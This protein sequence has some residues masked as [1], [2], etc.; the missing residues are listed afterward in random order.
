M[1]STG[2]NLIAGDITAFKKITSGYFLVKYGQN[3][4]WSNYVTALN[5]DGEAGARKI[6]YS[7]NQKPVEDIDTVMLA[8][9][10]KFYINIAGA[11]CK[12]NKPGLTPFNAISSY[13]TGEAFV[14]N[15]K[16]CTIIDGINGYGLKHNSNMIIN[17]P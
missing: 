10:G 2:K 17:P 5:A 7:L 1:N 6:N 8:P 13:D 4:K 3:K 12:N 15:N 16:T 11:W 9:N 14:V